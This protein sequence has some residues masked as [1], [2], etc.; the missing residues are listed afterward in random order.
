MKKLTISK[1]KNK[2]IKILGC[3]LFVLIAIVISV[4]A[5][6][7]NE[8]Q[9]EPRQQ[10]QDIYFTGDYPSVA[11]VSYIADDGK[12]YQF[13]AFEGH[14]E[15]FFDLQTPYEQARRIIAENGGTILSQIID[16][17]YF[18][19]GVEAGSEDSFIKKV[20]REPSVGYAFLNTVLYPCAVNAY[21]L[22]DTQNPDKYG[23]IHGE[24]V[25]KVA[26]AACGDCFVNKY[27][28]SVTNTEGQQELSSNKE[29]EYIDIIFSKEADSPILINMSYGTPL[30]DTTDSATKYT[31]ILE[32]EIKDK[33]QLIDNWAQS[34]VEFIKGVI[35]AV[36]P[37]KDRD[38]I[39][40]KS[41]GNNACYEFDEVILKLL[42]KELTPEEREIM[43]DHILLVSAYDEVV[44]VR[45]R[46]DSLKN[47]H[48]HNVD[49][50]WW[51]TYGK[52]SDRP[53]TYHQWVTTTNISHLSYNDGISID[54]TSF[55]AP[56]ALGN[57][58][59]VI[60][61]YDITA[62]EALQAVKK[63]T[64]ED[65]NKNGGA[66]MLNAIALDK[67][68]NKIAKR[69]STQF[70]G[71]WI[72]EWQSTKL[73]LKQN[74]SQLTG[75]YHTTSHGTEWDTPEGMQSIKGTI[76]GN[77]A[78]FSYTCFDEESYKEY[79]KKVTANIK[80]LSDTKMEW[81]IDGR[82]CGYLYKQ[83]DETL[84]E[85]SF[86][87]ELS[88]DRKSFELSDGSRLYASLMTWGL[89]DLALDIS[90]SGK[91]PVKLEWQ[92]NGYGMTPTSG[93]EYSYKNIRDEFNTLQEYVSFRWAEEE[94][95]VNGVNFTISPISDEDI[96]D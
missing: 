58:A 8:S 61:K 88:P 92:L 42:E 94:V 70:T 81:I 32:S 21:V 39:I 60:D 47:L 49:E 91:T 82:S 40:T 93:I 12:K 36:T 67:E 87:I 1:S 73:E 78:S 54:G 25:A 80:L 16:M 68:A 30:R 55:A 50:T 13:E 63:V 35:K 20:E 72:D 41:A 14:V 95:G 37:Y 59:R 4:T 65:A 62:K 66:G 9:H 57:I 19:V 71:V 29:K 11:K 75:Y 22:D 69:R 44:K 84:Q 46:N 18:L 56:N 26:V 38:F 96:T 64:K 83:K 2:R 10:P 45:D 34:Y 3:A 24:D 28:I 86:Y 90:W 7:K 23:H 33:Q 27:N 5:I 17:N 76:S 89:G 43:D 77:I 48:M 85:A 79:S 51:N 52:Y 31:V 74:G 15:I 6:D 53:E